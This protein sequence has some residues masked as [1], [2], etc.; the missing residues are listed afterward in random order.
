MEVKMEIKNLKDLKDALKNIPDEILEEFGAGW[1]PEFLE[2][3]VSLL[4]YSDESEFGSK[5]EEAK[6]I[7]LPVSEIAKW[8]ENIAKVGHLINVEEDYEGVGFEEMISSEDFK[9]EDKKS[10]S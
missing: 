8:I 7:G 2:N 9:E 10:S 3:E 4:V 5:F 1:N 6:K